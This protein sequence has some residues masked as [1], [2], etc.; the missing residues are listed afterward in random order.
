VQ[1]RDRLFP[2]GLAPGAAGTA[3]NRMVSHG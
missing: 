3:V 1:P 2:N